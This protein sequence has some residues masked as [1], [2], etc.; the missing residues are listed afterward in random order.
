[1][2]RP[3]VVTVNAKSLPIWMRV[4]MFGGAATKEMTRL[5]EFKLVLTGRRGIPGALLWGALWAVARL[6][7]A[8]APAVVVPS[9]GFPRALPEILAAAQQAGIPI[10]R[11]EQR[12]ERRSAVPG[13]SV[14]AL[15]SLSQGAKLEQWVLGLT[16]AAL[17][18]QETR[19]PPLKEFR[20]YSSTGTES[21]FGGR[22]AAITVAL[23]GPVSRGAPA[24]AK[25]SS[26]A[27]R[28]RILVNAEYLEFGFDDA[29]EAT[30]SMREENRG[31]G[32]G[33]KLDYR[34][35]RTPFPAA[36]VRAN[37]PLA[38]RR[39]LTAARERALIGSGL[40]LPEFLR[41]IAK[42]PGLQ[43]ILRNVIDVSWWS[44]LTRGS[45]GKLK[46]RP[47]IPYV[48]KLDGK[49]SGGSPP[50]YFLP[51]AI[52]LN[53]EPALSCALLVKEPRAP[54]ATTAGVFGV[55]ACRP[56]SQDLQLTI[57]LIAGRCHVEAGAP[58]GPAEPGVPRE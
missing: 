28:G 55:A 45:T 6:G 29:C 33:E 58:G 38:V 53:E 39:G 24:A 44:V 1:M 13:D 12:A 43:D 19:L 46:S 31:D 21:R 18:E 32:G 22:R 16:T 51:V 26:A 2:V 56:Y 50:G 49:P 41:L 15:I 48:R 40:A 17:T 42:T 23:V 11:F 10:D 34:I 30:L 14:T 4:S 52:L 37:Q 9:F 47:L 54:F 36:V 5:P 35:E 3:H 57:R 25:P 20:A 8:E 27:R 7:A